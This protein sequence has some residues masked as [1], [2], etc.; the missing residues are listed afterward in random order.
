MKSQVHDLAWPASQLGEAM[1]AIARKS[2]L[3]P[4]HSE[5][6][7]PTPSL[8]RNTLEATSRWVEM[9]AGLLGLEAE[10]VEI[11]YTEVERFVRG[12]GPAILPLPCKDERRYLALLKSAGRNVAVLAPDL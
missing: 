11:T 7:N 9:A 8:I 10:P 6:T 5:V 12:A 1:E 3:A 2:G 4:R